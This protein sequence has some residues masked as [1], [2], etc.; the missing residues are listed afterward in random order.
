[1]ALVDGVLKA[2]KKVFVGCGVCSLMI[3]NGHQGPFW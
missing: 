2:L 1:M 3:G